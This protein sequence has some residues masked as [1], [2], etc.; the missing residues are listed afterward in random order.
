MAGAE[1]P[2]VDRKLTRGKPKNAT[3][4]TVLAA[5][6]YGADRTGRAGYS[7]AFVE[8]VRHCEY[9]QFLWDQLPLASSRGPKESILRLDH[10]QPIGTHGH[11]IRVSDYRLSEEALEIVDELVFWLV[12]GGSDEKSLLVAYRHQIESTFAS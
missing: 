9:P 6:Y 5:P 8:R 4:P 2:R 1:S 10:I 3:A 11:S 7:P 12:W